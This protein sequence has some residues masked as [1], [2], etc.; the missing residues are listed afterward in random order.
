MRLCTDH[1]EVFEALRFLECDPEICGGGDEDV[2]FSIKADNSRYQIL[3]GSLVDQ[4]A[5][6][7]AVAASLYERLTML[8]LS[9]FPR[10]PLIHAASLRREDGGWFSSARK[11]R[12]KPRSP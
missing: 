11:V 10:A 9:D 12:E 7:Q 3:A 4:Y 8:S 6:P 2:V 1:H 5:S